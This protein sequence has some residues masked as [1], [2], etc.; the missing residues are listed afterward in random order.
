M[1]KMLVVTVFAFAAWAGEWKGAISDAKC[2]AKHADG[3]ACAK[4]CV[5][6][7]GAPVFVSD[8]KVYK[9][10]NADKATALAGEKVVVSGKI[11]GEDLTIASIK[12][13]E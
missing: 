12:K 9:I 8:G 4:G 2:G 13:S 3:G 1:K 11:E 7:G 6:K 5:A 10:T